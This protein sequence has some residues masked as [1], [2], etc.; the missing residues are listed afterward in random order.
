M[1]LTPS[2][3]PYQ[4]REDVLEA[5]E[6][7]PAMRPE[8]ILR[9]IGAAGLILVV[10]LVLGGFTFHE[11]N[12]R[13][14]AYY[15]LALCLGVVLTAVAFQRFELALALFISVIW[16]NFGGTPDL[17]K[18]VSS[19]T[20]KSLF[21]VELGVMFLI[22]IWILRSV[23]LGRLRIAWTPMN[24]PLVA[25]LLFSVWTAVNGYLFWDP[26]LTRFY[27][28]LPG[29]GRTAP[30]VTVLELMLRVLSVSTFWLIASSLTDVRW[31]RRISL[32]LMLPGVLICLLYYHVL[33]SVGGWKPAGD[34]S[35]LVEI[36]PACALWAWL[37]EA[38]SKSPG[39]RVLA[40]VGLG[41]LVF[42]LFFVG[43][44]WISG[45]LALFVGLFF[46]ALLK[47][48]RLFAGLVALGLI[49]VLASVPFLKTHVIQDVETSGDMDRFSLLRGALLYALHFPFGI[50]PGNFRAYN[51]Y[52]GSASMWHTTVYTSAH[53]FYAQTLSEMGFAGL[54]LTLL[55]VFVGIWMLVRFYRQCP[56]GF[57]R[58]TIL[59]IAGAW[60]GICAAGVVG[61]YLIPVYHNGGLINLSSTIYAWIGLGVAVAHACQ[62]NLLKTASAPVDRTQ[63]LTVPAAQYY[64]RRLSP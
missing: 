57:S 21:P 30:Q 8:D 59:S 41:M 9:L 60:T 63:S 45:W 12:G 25:Y 38:R 58:T 61:D 62:M 29:G 35:A 3:Y 10:G 31:L 54:L 6:T 18:G 22:F 13:G 44:S 37:L 50:G 24:W 36:L 26:A 43:I 23:G 27:A 32:L 39:L 46:I 2:D 17:A 42:Q 48:K 64:P 47:S 51:T 14:T 53:D 56:P 52:Y 1:S 19:G 49:L 40:W 16:I 7:A 28:G 20:G 5:P 33:P 15:V 34:W 11:L 55:W 4:R